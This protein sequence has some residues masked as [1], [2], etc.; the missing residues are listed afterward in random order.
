MGI[1]IYHSIYDLLGI[2]I[3]RAFLLER[4]V[5]TK[6]SEAVLGSPPLECIFGHIPFSRR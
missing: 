6:D 4:S 2:P 1:Y 3:M 5:A